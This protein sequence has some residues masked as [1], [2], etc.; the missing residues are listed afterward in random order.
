MSAK[1][2]SEWA[3]YLNNPLVLVA[4][5]LLMFTMAAITLS[6]FSSKP[7]KQQKGLLLLFVLV[8][9]ITIFGL[10][11]AFNKQNMETV[12]PKNN[13]EQKSSGNKSPNV[14]TGGNANIS[15]G[16]NTSKGKR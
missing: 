6:A 9:V 16:G 12:V 10:R 7:L 1:D 4:F 8:A 3:K 11:L 2:Y 14:V 15:F 13:I 5:A